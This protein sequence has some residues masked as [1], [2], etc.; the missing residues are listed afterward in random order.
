MIDVVA[1]LDQATAQL[2]VESL[3][4]A[5]YADASTAREAARV[6]RSFNVVHVESAVKVDIFVAGADPLD[7]ER[8]RR[9]QRID[10][11]ALDERAT[12]FIDTPEDVILRKLEWYRRG[13]DTSERQWRDVLAVL[14]VQTHLDDAYV[15]AWA[16]SLRSVAIRPAC[17]RTAAADVRARRRNTNGAHLHLHRQESRRI[18][19]P[20]SR[21]LTD[22]IRSVRSALSPA[23]EARWPRP[24]RKAAARSR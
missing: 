10:V 1:D 24:I 7:Q 9:R 17:S 21:S 18:S 8:L 5:F 12:L 23:A 14:R 13:G 4:D 16:G 3:G 6:G 19:R 15:R 22:G 20:S 2:F 11:N